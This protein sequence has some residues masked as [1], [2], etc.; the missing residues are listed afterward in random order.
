MNDSTG[1][2]LLFFLALLIVFGISSSSKI[3]LG[4]RF[5]GLPPMRSEYKA[6][7]RKYCKFYRG[8]ASS[9][10]TNFEKRV[11]YFIKSKTFVPRGFDQVT[12]EMKVLIS[13]TAI[14]LIYGFPD[15]YLSHFKHILIY[16]DNYYSTINKMYHQGE[17]NPLNKLIVLSWKSFMRGM[18]EENDGINLGLHEMAHAIRLENIIRNDEYN[19]LDHSV[20]SQWEKLASEEMGRIRNG[21]QSI[22]REYG[23]TSEEEFFAVAVENFFERPALF[24]QYHQSL[25]L[26]LS[27]LLKQNI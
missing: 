9:Q 24:R 7:L 12:G 18:I 1:P 8:L 16:P 4:F 23:S 25:Y 11:Q 3:N 19:F 21:D 15:I 13:A 2:F 20:L 6:I 5:I 10:K 26:V 22:F 17:V 27:Q 14:Q